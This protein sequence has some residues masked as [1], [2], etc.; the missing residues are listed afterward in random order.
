MP[1]RAHPEDAGLDLRA[2]EDATIYPHGSAVFDNGVHLGI[3]P[4]WYGKIESR[5]GLNIKHGIV[6][7]GGVIDSGYTGSI[8]VKL[9]NLGERV[10]RVRRGDKIAQLVLMPCGAP[11]LEQVDELEVTDRGD[12]GFGSTGR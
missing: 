9:Y 3:T 4:T 11:A 1:E 6:S 2:R 12:G 5:S 8:A 10:Y 7:C